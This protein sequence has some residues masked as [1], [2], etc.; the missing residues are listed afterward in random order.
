MDAA[1]LQAELLLSGGDHASAAAALE[2]LLPRATDTLD[3]ARV[4]LALSRAYPR[5]GRPQDCV[6]VATEALHLL[7]RCDELGLLCEARAQLSLAFS[8]LALG[9]DALEQ[10]LSALSLARQLQDPEREGWALA[11]LGNAYAA[12]DNPAQARETTQL[13]REIAE[14]HGL[15]ELD[16]ACLNNQAYFTLDECE[17]LHIDGETEQAIVVQA[18]AQLLSEQALAC[19]QAQANPYKVALALSN[20]VEALLQGQDWARAQ[21]LID[22]LD[23]SSQEHGFHALATSTRLH[24]AM[25]DRGRGRLESAID[26]AEDL[27]RLTGEAMAPR[28]HR[29]A[30]RLLYECHKSAGN[31]A[32]ALSD[33]EQLM[34]AERVAIRTAQVAQTQVLL[35]RQE[36]D[37]AVARAE[38]A[39]A[40]ADRERERVLALERE[41]ELLREQLARSDRAAREDVLTHLANRRHAEHA[42]PLLWQQADRSVQPMAA[43]LLD[44]DHFKLVN[45]RCGHAIG[46][47]VLR[48]LASLLRQR[49]RSADLLARWG[50]EEFLICL[51]G[52]A[53]R[54]AEAVLERLRVAVS[55]HAWERVHAG[56]RLTISIGLAQRGQGGAAK[57]PD[58]RALV[59]CA[60]VAL[61]QAKNAGRNRLRQA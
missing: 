20:L 39:R 31:A 7:E 16:F 11:R 15:S 43:A 59:Q 60:D 8:L 36:V 46:D 52:P 54:E 49:L 61:Y 55:E 4:L 10:A 34:L 24:R 21:P 56:L 19:A 41:H 17:Q 26:I 6:R 58:P 23:Q 38:H 28:L 1:R 33:L 50:G 9:R 53:A 25:M 2:A 47:M 42:M 51:V 40:D 12:L 5:L 29:R 18:M 44:I 14:R 45:D 27:L 13:A 32:A 48:E 22:F 35:I 30:L 57:V 37:Q 3:R